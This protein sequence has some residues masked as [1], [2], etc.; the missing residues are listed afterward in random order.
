MAGLV[1]VPFLAYQAEPS[2]PVLAFL[3]VMELILTYQLMVEG[4]SKDAGVR[5]TPYDWSKLSARQHLGIALGLRVAAIASCLWLLTALLGGL[6]HLAALPVLAFGALALAVA[7]PTALKPASLKLFS[8]NEVAIFTCMVAAALP[9][10]GLRN[11]VLI[12][13]L[14][15]LWYVTCNRALWGRWGAPKI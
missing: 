5:Q 10:L 7:V 9:A 13:L 1:L 8:V 4:P 6:V 12:V 15:L 11:A 2:M 3:A 14:P